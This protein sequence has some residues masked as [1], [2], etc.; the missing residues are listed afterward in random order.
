[1]TSLS[2][3]PF[4]RITIPF[5]IGTGLYE[6]LGYQ[7]PGVWFFVVMILSMLIISMFILQVVPMPS[8]T[9]RWISG[10]PLII[11]LLMLGFL[12]YSMY[13]NLDRS[14]REWLSGSNCRGDLVGVAVLE[15]I[16][17]RKT[18]SLAAE[19]SIV[20][21]SDESGVCRGGGFFVM[22]YF[23]DDSSTAT[24]GKGDTLLI[25]YTISGVESGGNPGGFDYG[26]YLRRK[27]IHH[28]AWLGDGNWKLLSQGKQG[29]LSSLT[30]NARSAICTRINSSGLDPAN[31]GLALALLIGIKD[32]LDP[33]VNRSFSEA[34]AIH[35]LCVSGLHVGII[36]IMVSAILGYLRKIPRWG[37]PVFFCTG[38]IAIWGYAMV[39]GMPP[40]VNRASV[41]FSFMLAGKLTMRKTP[42]MNSV[43]ASAFILLLDEPPV[44]F[45]AG[46]QLSYLAVTGIIT[47]HPIIASLWS[48]GNKIMIK[49]RDLLS[50][51]FCA[52][53]F[54]FPVAL[55]IFGIFP[56]YFLLTNLLVIPVTGFVIYTGVLY[57]A[58]PIESISPF[59]EIIF[60]TM[61]TFMRFLVGIVDGLPGSVTADIYLSQMQMWMLLL[62]VFTVML[63][64]NGEGRKFLHLSI[65]V[66]MIFFA[67]TTYHAYSVSKLNEVVF[68]QVKRSGVTDFVSQGRLI[69]VHSND[70]I[71]ERYIAFAAQGYRLMVGVSSVCTGNP[72]VVLH[73]GTLTIVTHPAGK[74]L[75]INGLP[76]KSDKRISCKVAVI[77]SSL[78][79][80][81]DIF[82]LV[83]AE[84][85]LVDGSMPLW[86]AGRWM[87]MAEGKVVRNTAIQGCFR[88]R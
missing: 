57:V 66:L 41:M 38:I 42:P 81:T 30:H 16:P 23:P 2:Q 62:C 40:S 63:W 85:W 82:S 52:Q 6:Y 75:F 61:L 3:I 77:G 54:T 79:P 7:Q 36:F 53:L 14:T 44:L 20:G 12:R 68:Y 74:V 26:K 56:N 49:I 32:E 39:T 43:F 21:I 59:T 18:K 69:S 83:D 10:L 51:S 34:G 58:L 71:P 28:T 9:H 5:A 11:I 24:L 29:V 87:E 31:K 33:E 22:G 37:K 78:R 86:K 13:E 46:F 35:V 25:K 70:T 84:I 45:N 17:R 48:P 64:V 1:M 76:E 80:A 19:L 8:Y 65:F 73:D 88:L 55:K 4:F 50:V 60:N 27:G 72:D 47:L 15:E 67:Y